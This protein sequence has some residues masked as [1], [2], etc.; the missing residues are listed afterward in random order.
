M[1]M[2]ETCDY[3]EDVDMGY[4]QNDVRTSAYPAYIVACLMHHIMNLSLKALV[5][6]PL[7]RE[8]SDLAT[9]VMMWHT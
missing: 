8:C 4:F 6:V 5:H 3:P 7:I 2:L 9:G 1:D